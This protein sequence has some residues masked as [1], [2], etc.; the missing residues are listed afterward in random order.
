[1]AEADNVAV[2]GSR[3]AGLAIAAAAVEVAIAAEACT[4]DVEERRGDAGDYNM[5]YGMAVESSHIA[6]VGI[7][8]ASWHCSYDQASCSSREAAS[9]AGLTVSSQYSACEATGDGAGG[10]T[11]R[12][13]DGYRGLCGYTRR[14]SGSCVSVRLCG[15]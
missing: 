4:G 7:R 3:L 14:R 6:V 1:M 13:G 11:R 8:S 9:S 12:Q 2:A 10:S 5:D 15:S